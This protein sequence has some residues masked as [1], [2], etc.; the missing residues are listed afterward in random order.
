MPTINVLVAHQGATDDEAQR[1]AAVD[2]SVRVTRALYVDPMVTDWILSLRKPEDRGLPLPTSDAFFAALSEAEVIF[3]VRLPDDILQLAPKLKW[4]QVYGAGVDYL[5]KTGILERG[6][7]LSN[8]S[9]VNAPPI[10][11]FVLGYMIM[12]VKHMAERV[13]AQRRGEWRR[14][15]ND[16]LEGKTLGIVGPG[17]IGGE[18][19]RRA[20]PF[21]MRIIAARRSYTPGEKLPNIERVYPMGQLREMLTRCD[22]VLV[23]VSLSK[24]SQRLIGQGEFAAMK[25]GAYFMNVA[26]GGVV[27]QQAL[28]SALQSGH[29]GGAALDVFDPE[30]LESDSPLWRMPNV[31]V[32]PHNSGGYIRHEERSSAF[33]CEN[34]RRYIRGE[35]LLNRVDPKAGY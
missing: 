13:E 9:G 3:C 33:F 24:E 11:E 14:M 31:F 10:A 6:I 20:A 19:A 30:P 15:M 18:T 23:S 26:R 12:H 1:I 7:L 34:L 22:Y 8:S 5:Q 2:P 21:G 16:S 17:H 28:I 27:D 29:L 25:R 4:V 32:T 35:A